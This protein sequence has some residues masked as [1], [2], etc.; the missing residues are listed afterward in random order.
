MGLVAT[1]QRCPGVNR[2]KC[3]ALLTALSLLAA[4]GRAQDRPPLEDLYRLFQV[5]LP[6]ADVVIL[7]DA[8]RSMAG[9]QYGSVRRSV[10]NFAP[11][12]TDK[13]NVQL[14]VFGDTVSNPLEGRGGEVAGKIEGFLPQEPFFSHTDLGLAILKGLEFL[15]RGDA[16][17]VQTLFLL[18]DGLHQPPAD[19]PYSRDFDSDPD[20]QDLR[21]R[22][23]APLPAAHSLRLRLRVGAADRHLRAAPRLPRAQRRSN[24]RRR[25]AGRIHA[26]ARAPL[27]IPRRRFTRRRGVREAGVP[28]R[29]RRRPQARLRDRRRDA[30]GVGAD[31]LP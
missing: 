16:S 1:H 19:S 22:A 30:R 29:G 23:E 27:R 9:H 12:L 26:P 5:D 28:D 4:T 31:A 3:L 6:P 17:Q 20:W 15:E 11:A 25:G 24:R 21:R 14:R 18:T 8:S 10:V 7:L 13:E 2:P